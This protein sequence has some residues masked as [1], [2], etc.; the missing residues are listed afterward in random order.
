MFCVSPPSPLDAKS[1]M[2][3]PSFRLFFFFFFFFFFVVAALDN[4]RRVSKQ[5]MAEQTQKKVVGS[6]W[7]GEGVVVGILMIIFPALSSLSS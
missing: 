3:L 2:I 5:M 4:K 7:V 6:G 1:G